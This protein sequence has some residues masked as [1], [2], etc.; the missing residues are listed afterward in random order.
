MRKHEARL[1]ENF[2]TLQL[3]KDF[4]CYRLTGEYAVDMAD[5]SGTLLLD[6]AYGRWSTEMTN[7]ASLNPTVLPSC[8]SRVRFAEKY[9][10]KEQR[11]PDSLLEF[12]LCLVQEIRLPVPWA[13]RSGSRR[14]SCH[15]RDIGRGLWLPPAGQRWILGH[16]CTLFA[17]LTN[18]STNSRSTRCWVRTENANQHFLGTA[19]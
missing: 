1:F 2:S 8:S 19:T 10:S 5:A 3:P 6:V 14:R 9:R 12:P 15:A 16:D 4:V 17:T 11:Q 7:A 18:G 13:R